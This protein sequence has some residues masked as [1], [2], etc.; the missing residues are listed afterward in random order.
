MRSG[1]RKKMPALNSLSR[2]EREP[3]RLL[4]VGGDFNRQPAA[5]M[6][7]LNLRFVIATG[8]ESQRPIGMSAIYVKMIVAATERDTSPIPPF[9]KFSFSN[10]IRITYNAFVGMLQR[11]PRY[12]RNHGT[13]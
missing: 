8:C 12:G 3:R 4:F 6:Q 10:V 5:E 1:R 9:G 7:A 11:P 13:F 2:T